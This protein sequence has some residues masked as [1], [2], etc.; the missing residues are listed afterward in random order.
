MSAQKFKTWIFTLEGLNAFATGFY[1]NWLFFFTQRELHFGPAENLG[2]VALH[3]L[4]YTGSAWFGGWFAHRFGRFASL[5]IGWAI[6]AVAL[7]CGALFH[8]A[9][10]QLAVVLLWTF[11]MCFTW[12]TLQHFVSR[13]EPASR[14]PKLAGIYNIVWSGIAALSFFVGGTVLEKLGARSMFWLPSAIHIFQFAFVFWLERQTVEE[15]LA[16]AKNESIHAEETNRSKQKLF[17]RLALLANPFAYV[18]IN[19]VIPMMPEIA[20]RF[21]LSPMWVGIF[22]SVWFFIR[23]GS[24]IFFW[25]WP[26]WHYRFTWLV[27]A[28]VAML[29][30]FVGILLAPQMWLLFLAQIVFGLSIGLI[31]YSS[32]FYS[33]DSG[34]SKSEHGGLHEAM[35]GLGTLLGA[36]VGAGAKYFWPNV[37]GISAWAV[38]G[39]L[40]A[41]FIALICLR[42]QKVQE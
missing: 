13:G 33:I 26:G 7:G 39:L 16:I 21:E 28:N 42:W 12:P 24:F 5:K 29:L 27:V 23:A 2:I 18:A 6:M 35:I 8:H 38:S 30:S 25:L 3:G 37:A 41:G 20:K 11:G 4:L 10:G 9:F 22:C 36:G 40:L 15:P 19:T 32:L 1:F 34:A 31:Y 17:L 14:M